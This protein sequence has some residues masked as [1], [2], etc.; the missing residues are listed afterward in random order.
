MTTDA[1]THFPSLFYPHLD[2]LIIHFYPAVP[3]SSAPWRD[4]LD[5]DAEFLQASVRPHT[6]PDD[7]ETQTVTALME[8]NRERVHFFDPLFELVLSAGCHG[9]HIVIPPIV[10]LNAKGGIVKNWTGGESQTRRRLVME[11]GSG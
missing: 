8:I 11:V 9:V 7:G 4:R 2:D 10:L 3:L 6:H 1:L 5:E